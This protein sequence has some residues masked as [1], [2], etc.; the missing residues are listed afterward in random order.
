MG[1]TRLGNEIQLLIGL[2][3]GLTVGHGNW[4]ANLV[5]TIFLFS[6]LAVKME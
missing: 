5:N 1:Q 4:R 2:E 6:L 3:M